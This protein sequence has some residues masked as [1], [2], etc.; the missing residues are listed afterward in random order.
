MGIDKKNVRLVLHADISGSLESYLQEAGRAGRDLRNA[1]C[2]LLYD[3]KDIETQF[4]LGRTSGSAARH[5]A[6]P[7]G[8]SPRAPQSRGRGI[9]T[10]GELLRDEEV[11]TSFDLEDRRRTPR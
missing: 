6:D 3:E 1:E 2:V 7:P 8:H 9:I 4:R 5:R 11:E 10:A